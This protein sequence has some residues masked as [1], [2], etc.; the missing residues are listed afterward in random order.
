M[1]SGKRISNSH[2]MRYRRQVAYFLEMNEQKLS[3]MGFAEE[4]RKFLQAES[5]IDRFKYSLHG[6][7]YRQK[8]IET[9]A[10]YAAVIAG[11]F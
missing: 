9:L 3:E 4:L 11:K 5:F 8:K 7:L 1:E 2:G 6:R 10:F